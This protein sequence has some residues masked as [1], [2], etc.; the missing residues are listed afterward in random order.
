MRKILLIFLSVHILTACQSKLDAQLDFVLDSANGNRKELE[1]VIAY[2]DSIGD[3]E[4]SYAAK[5]LIANMSDKYSY[6]GGVL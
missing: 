6:S 3:T 1:R 4:K 5:W 2:Y